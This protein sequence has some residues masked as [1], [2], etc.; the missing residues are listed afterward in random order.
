[1]KAKLDV[2]PLSREDYVN[3]Q[4]SVEREDGELGRWLMGRMTRAAAACM[5]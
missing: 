5:A 3:P 1:M 4:A 2:Q